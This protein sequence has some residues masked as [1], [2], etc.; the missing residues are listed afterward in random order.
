MSPWT[1]YAPF[2]SGGMTVN[3]EHEGPFKIIKVDGEV[4]LKKNC[5][6]DKFA[7]EDL[8]KKNKLN[9]RIVT[10]G[11]QKYGYFLKYHVNDMP[12]ADYVKN[13]HV[14]YP[15]WEI[16][17]THTRVCFDKN[18]NEIY[19][20]GCRLE[21]D[22]KRE[23]TDE[24]CTITFPVAGGEGEIKVQGSGDPNIGLQYL[25]FLDGIKRMPSCD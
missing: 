11:T 7:G 21:N 4:I 16:V 14:H 12:L 13:H 8:F 22:V 19:I 10:T 24:G 5:G 1:F 25:F 23:F 3:I 2:K 20:D 15:T 17:E 6:E 9:F 18:E